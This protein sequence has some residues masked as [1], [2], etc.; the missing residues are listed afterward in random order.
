MKGNGFILIIIIIFALIFF[1]QNGINKIKLEPVQS[2]QDTGSSIWEGGKKV[3]D[4][5]KDVYEVIR[6]N[7]AN[8][9]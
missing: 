3:V 2:V 4:T 9:S 7:Y 1:I 5:S 8:N 6:I